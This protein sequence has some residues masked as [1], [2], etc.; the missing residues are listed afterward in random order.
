MRTFYFILALIL[1][2][3]TGYFLK[4]KGILFSDSKLD[5]EIS[6]QF[7]PEELITISERYTPDYLAGECEKKK[8]KRFDI[9]DIQNKYYYLSGYTGYDH[10]EDYFERFASEKINAN[11]ITRIISYGFKDE[12]PYTALIKYLAEHKTEPSSEVMN[13]PGF[14]NDSTYILKDVVF[15]DVGY[16]IGNNGFTIVIYPVK[17]YISMNKPAPKEDKIAEK[18]SIEKPKEEITEEETED[19]SDAIVSVNEATIY[20]E[21]NDFFREG[22]LKKGNGL[23]I[24]KQEGKYYYCDFI[25]DDGEAKTGYFSQDDI[26]IK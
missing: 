6:S 8:F 25:G 2:V 20:R 23:K 26:K 16:L 10:N 18:K 7:S 24:I 1:I 4:T 17:D 13:L 12:K 19:F 21:A 11:S 14:N 15:V 22:I 3:A 5:S 9:S